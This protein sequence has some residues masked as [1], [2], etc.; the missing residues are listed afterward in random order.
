MSYHTTNIILKKHQKKE[1]DYCNYNSHLAKL[2]KNSVII[3]KWG[4]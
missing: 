4:V 1:L 2:F 3:P